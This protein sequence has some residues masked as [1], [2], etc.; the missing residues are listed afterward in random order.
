[1]E[2]RDVHHAYRQRVVLRGIDIRLRAGTLCGIVGE[3]G[4]GKSTLLKIL[5]GELR[6]SRG[7]VRH[8]GR[9]GYCPQ[10][11]V[12]NDALTVR[13]H[14]TFFQRAYRLADLRC[15]EQVMDV[16][17]FAEYADERA[18]VLSGGTRQK[19]NVTLA[20]MHDPQV[21]LLDEPY[22]GFDWDTYQRFWELAARLRD[23]GRSV[24]VVSHLAYDTERLDEL[25]RLDDGLLRPDQAVA[26]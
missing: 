16:L 8:G 10:H 15:A 2:V 1:M 22:Q 21:L 24:L 7:T 5:S 13:Q 4:A 17:G 14:L 3:N 12:L 20:L 26:A 11:V 9:F 19:L 23:T 6:P 25:W 18:A